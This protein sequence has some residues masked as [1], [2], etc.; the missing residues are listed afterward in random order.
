LHYSGLYVRVKP[1]KHERHFYNVLKYIERHNETLI[2]PLDE[3]CNGDSMSGDR[4]E[5]R[6]ERLEKDIEEIKNNIARLTD[7]IHNMVQPA[8]QR[9][10]EKAEAE[11]QQEAVEVNLSRINVRFQPARKGVAMRIRFA[12]YIKPNNKGEYYVVLTE[13]DVN[14]LIGAL[15]SAKGLFHRSEE[16]ENKTQNRSVKRSRSGKRTIRKGKYSDALKE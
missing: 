14:A 8:A 7:M 15:K 12:R 16:R 6:V 4:L 11:I 10:E 3:F 5:E 1:V 9:T 2:S 13:D